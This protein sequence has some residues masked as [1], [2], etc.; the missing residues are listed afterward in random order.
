MRRSK[1]Q[2]PEEEAKQ[3]LKTATNGV[4]SLVDSN[5]CPYG[6]PMSFIF[7]GVRAIYFHCALDGRKIDCIRNN[8]H[9]CFCVIDQDE[10]HPVEFT[11]YFRS[12]IAEGTVSIIAE[13][14]MMVEP[15][16]MLSCKYSP[17]IDCEPEIAKGINR[18]LVL[19]MTIESLTG[20]EAIEI[21]RQRIEDSNLL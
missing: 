10:V 6:V 17:N 14:E 16:R 2:I 19:R 4:L 11:T 8:P 20:K 5:G 1:Q 18:V 21:T 12:V 7:D 9:C 15:L 13:K 3:I